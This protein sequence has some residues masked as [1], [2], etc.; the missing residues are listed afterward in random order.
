MELLRPLLY[1]KACMGTAAA[2]YGTAVLRVLDNAK[3]LAIVI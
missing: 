1:L 2:L 3:A